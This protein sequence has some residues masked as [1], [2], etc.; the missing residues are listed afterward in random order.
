VWHASL[1]ETT[2]PQLLPLT[3]GA[4][5]IDPHVRLGAGGIVK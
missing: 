5:D 4:S 2:P 1:A 3:V